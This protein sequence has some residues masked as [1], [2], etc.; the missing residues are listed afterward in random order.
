VSYLLGQPVHLAFEVELD[1]VDTDPTALALVISKP[2]GTQS[3]VNP[4]H[5][6]SGLFSYDYAPPVA[7]RYTW[8]ATATGAVQAATS[9]LFDVVDAASTAAPLTGVTGW[10]DGN[11]V[12][13]RPGCDGIDQALLDQAAA[14]ASNL[15]Y[16]LTGRQYAGMRSGYVRPTARPR[17][18]DGASWARA[19]GFGWSGWGVCG[20]AYGSGYGG[21]SLAAWMG[22]SCSCY[23]AEVALG[24][25]PVTGI[26][27]VKIDGTVIPAEEYQVYERRLLVRQLTSDGAQPTARGGW[28]TCQRLDLPDT[29]PGTFSVRFTYGTPPPGDGVSAATSLAAEL[30]IL[31]DNSAAAD[32]IRLPTRVRTLARQG[33]TITLI[34]PQD[35]LDKGRTGIPDVDMFIKSENPGGL[36]RRSSVWSPDLGR[37]RRPS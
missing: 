31:W 23:P 2:D 34:D 28:P 35:V 1:A 9:G 10:T 11:A 29:E 19:I 15:L 25:Y 5:D 3:T 13:Q 17:G 8:V 6:G 16:K 32:E 7:G 12:A 27:E 30:A 18:V 22:H 26:T 4:D 14:A 24:A 21:A 20:S 36:Q 37:A 33:E